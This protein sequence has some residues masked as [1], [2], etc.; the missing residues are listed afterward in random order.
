MVVSGRGKRAR[1]YVVKGI[2]LYPVAP[3]PSLRS[4]SFATG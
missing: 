2:D 4:V 3:P 1:A